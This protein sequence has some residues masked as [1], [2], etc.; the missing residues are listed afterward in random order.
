MSKRDLE[1]LLLKEA[2]SLPP[3]DDKQAPALERFRD[4][5]E[6]GGETAV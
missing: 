2:S 1:I 6:E 3:F 4:W 5:L